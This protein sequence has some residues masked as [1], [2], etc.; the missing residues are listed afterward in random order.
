MPSGSLLSLLPFHAITVCDSTSFISSHTKKSAWSAFKV[1]Y[2]LLCVFGEGQLTDQKI[3]YAEKF[4]CR[5]Y[6]VSDIVCTTNEARLLLFGKLSSPVS[7]PPT[8]DAFEQHI[9]RTHYQSMVWECANVTAPQ[10]PHA[11]TLGWSIA[12]GKLSPI[13]MTIDPVPKACMEIISCQCLKGCGIMCCKC[14]KNMLV[15]SGT[16]KCK[17][18][19]KAMTKV[20]SMLPGKTK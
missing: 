3:K 5:L 4:V 15:C 17:I 12:D 1:Y 16:C 2:K 8:S 20:L 18:R 19:A 14:R 9:K 7:L 6:N 11:D 10:L 13:L